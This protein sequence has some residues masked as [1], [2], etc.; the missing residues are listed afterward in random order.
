MKDAQLNLEESHRS[1]D[2]IAARLKEVEKKV[3]TI[4]GDLSQAQEEVANADRARRTAENDRD[5]LQDELTT[6]SSK[7]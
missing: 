1:R 5:E 4:E 6:A 7:A 2:D 3:K